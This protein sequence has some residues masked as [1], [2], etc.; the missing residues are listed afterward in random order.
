MASDNQTTEGLTATAAV[1]HMAEKMRNMRVGDGEIEVSDAAI[2]HDRVKSKGDA[3]ER[4]A[5]GMI[6]KYAILVRNKKSYDSRKK[7]EIDSIIIQSPLLRQILHDVLKDYP[8]VTTT[9]SRLIFSAP[10]KP[11]VHRRRQLSAAVSGEHDEATELHLSLLKDVLYNELGGIIA[12]TED[13]IKHKVVSYEEI[14]TIFEPGCIVYANQSSK[15]IAARLFDSQFIQ[16]P[17]MGPCF[18]LKCQRVEWDGSR[19]GYSVMA[20][21]IAPFEGT[22]PITDLDCFPLS[23][24]PDE[25]GVKEKLI[26]RGR[27]FEKLAGYHYKSYRGPAIEITR[28]GPQMITVDGRIIVDGSAYRKANAHLR[29]YF[30][31][32]GRMEAAINVQANDSDDEW[33]EHDSVYD[34]NELEVHDTTV[35]HRHS[36]KAEQLLICAPVV[37]GYSLRAKLWLEFFVDSISEIVFSDNAFDSLV[38]PESHKSLILAIA[39]AQIQK[40]DVFDDVISGKGRGII[41][42]LSGGPGIGKTLTAESV[43]EHMRVP[44]YMMSAGD[45]GTTSSDVEAGITRV[46]SM[47]ARW[48]AILLLDECDV[49]LEARSTH[50]LDRNRIVS[51]FL[52]TLEYY[53]GL[54]FLTTNR[55]KN[56]DEAFNSRIHFQLEYPDLDANA[57]R[58]VWQGFLDRRQGGYDIGPEQLARL[59]RLEINGRIIKNV[60]KSATLL[61]SH[62]NEKLGFRHIETVLGVNGHNI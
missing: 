19:F 9:L 37:R 1:L 20:F 51:I 22:V 2:D 34:G 45:L 7:L 25:E 52:R 56:M 47:V 53:E 23:Y 58:A 38:M 54:L 42:L 35:K 32:I 17:E 46:L 55:V 28:F 24:H 10:F 15:P 21:F 48:N 29:L 44:L 50:D 60:L 61:A 31:S 59:E 39:Q 62:K 4:V 30:K 27:E 43:A 14:W 49:F 6:Y 57:R 33:F 40:K 8:G 18:Q 41:M 26:A 36:L 16:H 5:V 13:Y 12:A 3:D 11:F